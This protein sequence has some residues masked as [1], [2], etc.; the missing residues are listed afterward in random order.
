MNARDWFTLALRLFGI[1]VV[2]QTLTLMLAMASEVI[3]FLV[4]GQAPPLGGGYVFVLETSVAAVAG[5]ICGL[6]L[7]FRAPRIA[8]WFY[9]SPPD[10]AEAGPPLTI[11][12][13]GVYRIAAF[14]LGVYAWLQAVRP[15]VWA[16]VALVR[17]GGVTWQSEQIIGNLL[18]AVLFGL[19]GAALVFGSR[20][21]AQFLAQLRD[22]APDG[23]T[24]QF[25]LRLILVIVVG[26]AI[27]L[28]LIRW[29]T[30]PG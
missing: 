27:T 6:V 15:G 21:L 14:L 11:D 10:Q 23:P 17:Q 29:L 13:E 25:T 1:W 18:Q 16:V 5:L 30:I 19:I 26:T 3:L 20:G 22:D 24:A 2:V 12:T 7:L 8:R 4:A 9:R 28:G